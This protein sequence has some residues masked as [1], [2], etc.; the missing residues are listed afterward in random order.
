MTM[1]MTTRRPRHV[2]TFAETCLAALAGSGA[3]A[4][5]S[6]GGAFALA[7]YHE[8][9]TTNDVDAWWS[10]DCTEAEQRSV[11]ETITEALRAFGR[12]RERRHGDVVSIELEQDGKTVFSFQV[13]GRSAR[14]AAPVESPWP[15]V[16]LDTFDDL[17][18]AKMAALIARGAPRDFIDIHE[19]C[20]NELVTGDECWRL[21]AR[22]EGARGV[23]TP[24]RELAVE[25]VRLN[26]SRIERARPLETLSEPERT[27]AQEVRRWFRDQFCG[28]EL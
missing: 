24:E 11:L 14:L 15:P 10:E 12:V 8:F 13:A 19:L 17:V 25:A 4:H 21:W 22:R 16:G 28:P 1:R 7:H 3:G 18:A 9:R 2:S 23:P 26:L 5:V 20:R 6:L 27:Q